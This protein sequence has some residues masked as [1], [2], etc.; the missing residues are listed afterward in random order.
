VVSIDEGDELEVISDALFDAA[1][2]EDN[3]GKWTRPFKFT[4]L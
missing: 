1:G 4:K 3:E 2:V